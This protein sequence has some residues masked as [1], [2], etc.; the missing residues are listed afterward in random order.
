MILKKLINAFCRI[1]DAIWRTLGHVQKVDNTCEESNSASGNQTEGNPVTG[2]PAPDTPSETETGDKVEAETEDK[3][4]AETEDKAKTGTPPQN[5]GGRRGT[6]QPT[7]P[8]E[9]KPSK[10]DA[11]PELLCRKEMAHRQW[12]ILLSLPQGRGADV[13]Q[14]E[15]ELLPGNR[16]EYP[17][18]SFTDEVVV[19]W[20]ENEKVEK[21][22][23][24]DGAH[25]LIFKL[26]KNWKSRGRKVK[27]VS[28]G[29]Y[30]VF[31]PLDWNRTGT[32]PI[33][34]SAC[35]DNRFLAHYFF[36]GGNGESGGFEEFDSIFS[37]KRFSLEGQIIYDDSDRGNLY[38]GIPPR[39]TD[40]DKWQNIP[41]VRV[42]E[43]DDGNWGENFQPTKK[44]LENVLEKREG[45]FYIRIYDEGR[46]LIDTMDFRYLKDLEEIRVNG[47]PHS[48]GHI[49]A[50]TTSGHTEATVQ[51][52]GNIQVENPHITIG[53][54]NTAVIDQGPDMDRTEWT[55]IDE[56]GRVNVSV[57]LPRVWWCLENADDETR[58]WHDTAF[59]MTRDEFYN[60]PN[61]LVTIRLP[62]SVREIHAGFNTLNRYTGAR[63]YPVTRNED[64]GTKQAQ[65]EFQDFCYHREISEPSSKESTLKIQCGEVEF[66][67]VRVPA[68]APPSVPPPPDIY[69]S[70]K[71]T[72]RPVTGNKI[73]SLR[74]LKS[75]ELSISKARS[76]GIYVDRRRKTKHSDNVAQ[77]QTFLEENHAD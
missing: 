47:K 21:I 38:V 59:E 56:H 60:N 62:S 4:K 68:D 50:P 1:R 2:T 53:P 20:V 16:G 7:P 73:F 71:E 23:L 43:E 58:K 72:L 28:D 49:I 10:I 61:A 55:V 75:V 3:T 67:I 13:F 54:D 26:S 64:D 41:W 33:E 5:R 74:E 34:P 44:D 77:L 52:V 32:A 39:L 31:S 19:R 48:P 24:V 69:P 37:R 22:S 27:H 11:K 15:V 6:R 65:I 30:M 76:L 29:Y 25:P 51:F 40:T 45:W 12:Q 17:L 63:I 18:S 8:I 57:H 9:R 35:N 46:N 36:S 66:P 14:G 70:K 42:G